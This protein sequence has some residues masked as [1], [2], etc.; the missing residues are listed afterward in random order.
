MQ[1]NVTSLMRGVVDLRALNSNNKNSHDHDKGAAAA[2]DAKVEENMKVV[3]PEE[4]AGGVGG[5]ATAFSWAEAAGDGPRQ[6]A[7][8]VLVSRIYT[9][10]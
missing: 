9:K 7:N 8:A 6:H 4:L 10:C 3:Y 2:A 5:Q 1:T